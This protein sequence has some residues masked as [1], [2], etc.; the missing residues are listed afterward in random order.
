VGVTLGVT[1]GVPVAVSV[2]VAVGVLV[3]GT[4]V[5][6][7]VFDGGAG[8]TVA[9][10]VLVVEAVAVLVAVTVAVL[11]IVGVMVAVLVGVGVAMLV[12]RPMPKCVLVSLGVPFVQSISTICRVFWRPG[13]VATTP[14]VVV[15]TTFPASPTYT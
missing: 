15:S 2:R 10:G 14:S 7:A 5:L 1:V 8:V 3:D 13:R 9:A 6:V 12:T 4:G 11:V